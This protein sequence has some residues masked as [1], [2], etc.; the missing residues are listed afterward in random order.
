[1]QGVFVCVVLF[2]QKFAV[3][4]LKEHHSIGIIKEMSKH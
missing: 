2:S 4:F 3:Y 1:M